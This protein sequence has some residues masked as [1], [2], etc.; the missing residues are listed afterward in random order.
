MRFT[1]FFLLVFMVALS[2]SGCS[3]VR[4]QLN[5]QI[6]AQTELVACRTFE[7]EFMPET[8]SAVETAHEHEKEKRYAEAERLLRSELTKCQS[9]SDQ[10]SKKTAI[11]LRYEI[12][13]MEMLQSEN[14]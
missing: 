6:Q 4:Q 9:A 2:S 1:A 10:L 5:N 14:E 3:L 7:L 11:V 8:N 12:A 13:R